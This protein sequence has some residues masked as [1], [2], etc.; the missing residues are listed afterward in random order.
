[1]QI[2]SLLSRLDTFGRKIA[3]IYLKQVLKQI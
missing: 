3:N 1:M 2:E